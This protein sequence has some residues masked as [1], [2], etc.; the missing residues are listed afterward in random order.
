M[1]ITTFADRLTMSRAAAAEVPRHVKESD[2]IEVHAVRQ[3][4][5]SS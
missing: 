5:R 4:T 1:T 2:G 3:Q